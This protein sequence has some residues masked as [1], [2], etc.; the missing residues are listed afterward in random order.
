MT[1]G[2]KITITLISLAMF[3]LLSLFFFIAEYRDKINQASITRQQLSLLETFDIFTNTDERLRQLL[4]NSNRQAWLH[5]AKLHANNSADT[6]YQLAEYFH[7]H[8]QIQAAQLWYRLA[9]RQHHTPARIA[10]ASSYFAQQQYSAIKPLLLPIIANADALALLYELALYQGD[11]SFIENY[12]K[13]L[14]QGNSAALYLELKKFSVFDSKSVQSVNTENSV[15]KLSCFIDV[16]FF[17]TN[18]T[19]LRHAEQLISVFE[20]HRLAKFICLKAPKYIAVDTVKCSNLAHE[21]IACKATVWMNRKA[22][23]ARY[24][25]LVVAEGGA[26]VDNGILYLDQNDDIDVLVHELSHLIGFVDEYPLPAQHQRCQQLQQSPF[27]H[28]LVVLPEYYQ[29][30]RASVRAKVLSQVPWRSLIKDTTAI[31]SRHQKGWQLL[32]P[33][34]YQDEVG[35]FP[36]KSCDKHSEIQAFKPLTQRTKL[37]YFEMTFPAAYIDIFRLAPKR[38]LMPSYHFNISRDLAVQGHYGQA[39]E[40]LQSTLFE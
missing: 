28:N 10:L 15:S 3:I 13:Q 14:A 26:N 32:T 37:Q 29:G 30:D 34:K 6:A 7:Q 38:F 24:L 18:L 35:L 12:K 5:L 1:S 17:A 40:V 33:T 22:I 20:Q 23:N 31:L 39:R 2:K 11:V 27:A 16:Q 21:K 4:N 36:A 19:G 9:I 25:A 8:Q